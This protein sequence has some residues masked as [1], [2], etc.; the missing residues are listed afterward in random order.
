VH[1]V[2]VAEAS[3]I[4]LSGDLGRHDHRVGAVLLVAHAHLIRLDD[5]RSAFHFSAVVR[6][7]RVAIEKIVAISFVAVNGRFRKDG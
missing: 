3:E 6:T 7:A 2:S 4:D 1:I 5:P